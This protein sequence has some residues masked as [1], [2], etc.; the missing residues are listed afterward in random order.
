MSSNKKIEHYEE[1][2]CKEHHNSALN[3]NEGVDNVPIV[4]PYFK[5]KHRRTLTTK[6]FVE[7]ITAGD[8]T[9][10]SQ[11]ITLVESNNQQHYA[12]AQQIIEQCLP[13]AGKSVR[14]GITGVPGAG[15]ST[16]IEA[17]GGMV[18]GMGHKLAV[19]AIDPSSERSKGSILGDKTRMATIATNPNIF[20]RPSPSAGSLGGVARKT[21]ESIVLCEAA[22]FDVIFIETVGVGQSETA[23]HSMVDMFMM[24]Q[25]SGAGD[26]LQGIKRGIMEMADLVAITKADGDNVNKSKL[27][28]QHIA[29]A[30]MLFPTSDSQWR[31]EVFT[32]SSLEGTGLD[33]IWKNVEQYIEFVKGNGFFDHNRQL[34]SKY[35][36]YETINDALKSSFYNNADIERALPEFE[37]KVLDE[38]VS[39]FVAAKELLDKYFDLTN[40]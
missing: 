26:E 17:V 8:I 10:L 24:L 28:K 6:Q 3:I 39:S 7:G 14:L 25:I 11:A 34:Q 16:F 5:K 15:K 27:A 32:C 31:P 12:Q 23:V 29:N 37:Q 33:E 36:M 38:K 20:I 35:W 4:N 19:L 30:L 21:R 13:Y 2:H 22:G 9:V 18:E 40:K 1:H